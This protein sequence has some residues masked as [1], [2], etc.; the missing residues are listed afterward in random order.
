MDNSKTIAL[1]KKA[2]HD[3]SILETVEAGIELRGTEIK[4]L[5]DGNLNIRDAYAK[6]EHG[7]MYLCNAHI[8]K[9]QASNYLDHE[10]DRRRK[11]LLHKYQIRDMAADTVKKGLTIVPLKVYLKK[12]KAKVELGLAKGKKAFDKRDVMA[13]RSADREIER[14]LKKRIS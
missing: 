5:R 14:T 3:Y 10:P 11:L 12:G 1:N 8:A 6:V 7:E 2:Y 13:K 4:S 9:Y